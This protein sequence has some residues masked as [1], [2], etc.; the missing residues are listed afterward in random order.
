M[1]PPDGACLSEPER[2]HDSL[3]MDDFNKDDINTLQPP[4][5]KIQSV[6]GD[7]QNQ[8]QNDD[9]AGS[10]WEQAEERFLEL[11]FGKERGLGKGRF[12]YPQRSSK[13]SFDLTSN[14]HYGPPIHL[15]DE[16][17][18]LTS[19]C[20]ATPSSS[21][22]I[23]R[24]RTADLS[25]EQKTRLNA[26]R[27][28]DELVFLRPPSAATGRRL[29]SASA[30][31]VLHGDRGRR[32]ISARR[33]TMMG[34]EPLD[35]LF[36]PRK[37]R[38]L[39]RETKSLFF[40]VI[41]D[42]FRTAWTA[43]SV[44]PD[45]ATVQ[46]S[47]RHLAP[48]AD[49]AL[50]PIGTTG[51]TAGPK[52]YVR[53]PPQLGLHRIP[54]YYF[55]EE[56]GHVMVSHIAK[57]YP[58]PKLGRFSKRLT[59]SP[60]RI[61]ARMEG[62][63]GVSMPKMRGEER[64]EEHIN[65]GRPTPADVIQWLGDEVP[66][67]PSILLTEQ[68]DIDR[69]YTSLPDRPI[70]RPGRRLGHTFPIDFF[71]DHEDAQQQLVDPL[72]TQLDKAGVRTKGRAPGIQAPS[73]PDTPD[74]A[75]APAIAWH[76]CTV[77]SY[78]PTDNRYT[79]KWEEPLPERRNPPTQ[80]TR[81]DILLPHETPNAHHQK[82]L[83]AH[84]IRVEFEYRLALRQCVAIARP[85]LK[86]YIA[87][88]PVRASER[89]LAD[90]LRKR[91]KE[92]RQWTKFICGTTIGKGDHAGETE[93]EED[94]SLTFAPEVL[95]NLRAEIQNDYTRSQIEAALL[96]SGHLQRFLPQPLTIPTLSELHWQDERIRVTSSVKGQ[97]ARLAALLYPRIEFYRQKCTDAVFCL[98]NECQRLLKDGISDVLRRGEIP[99]DSEDLNTRC[100]FF[101]PKEFVEACA[102]I[103]G[104][105][106]Q[107][108]SEHIGNVL[109]A[110]VTTAF[111]A[112]QVEPRDSAET[113]LS[114]MEAQDAETARSL[115]KFFVA[116]IAK[117]TIM[118][119]F[120]TKITDIYKSFHQGAIRIRVDLI[121][122][123]NADYSITFS[124]DF[125]SWK[126]A[127]NKS[128]SC[129]LTPISCKFPTGPYIPTPEDHVFLKELCSEM[130]DEGIDSCRDFVNWLSA[131]ILPRVR[132]ASHVSVL[133]VDIA[134]PAEN[135]LNKCD[136]QLRDI[137]IV[138]KHCAGL[139][140]VT[141]RGMFAVFSENFQSEIKEWVSKTR[142][143]IFTNL[144]GLLDRK[145]QEIHDVYTTYTTHPPPGN[146]DQTKSAS[147]SLQ[148]L[149][150][151]LPLLQG[152][153]SFVKS[154]KSFLDERQWAVDDELVTRFYDAYTMYDR[155]TEF[156]A[157]RKQ[158]VSEA[159]ERLSAVV[160]KE[161]CM[162]VELWD[163][164][165]AAL[166]KVLTT[167]IGDATSSSG[168]DNEEQ[169][170]EEDR[171]EDDEHEDARAQNHPTTITL[172]SLTPISKHIVNAL[173]IAAV[174]IRKASCI[175]DTQRLSQLQNLHTSMHI[176]RVLVTCLLQYREDLDR[177]RY[178]PI[179][180]IHASEIR[181]RCAELL[182]VF[183]PTGIA[184]PPIAQHAAKEIAAFLET[185]YPI[186]E[187]LTYDSFRSWHWDSVRN[188][189]GLADFDITTTPLSLVTKTIGRRNLG[190]T[191]E[192]LLEI[193]QEA[194][195]EQSLS[196][197]LSEIQNRFAQLSIQI[198]RD[199]AT[200]LS[201]I[202]RFERLIGVIES[203]LLSVELLLEGSSEPGIEHYVDQFTALQNDLQR[204]L[205]SLTEWSKT[206][207]LLL[208]THSFF[209]ATEV[210]LA[211]PLETK[212]YR[213][214]ETTYRALLAKAEKNLGMKALVD[215]APD[216]AEGLTE[217]RGVLGSLVE[218][219]QGWLDG[220]RIGF[221]RLFF[222]A[223]EELL[224]L[225]KVK[226]EPKE[227]NGYLSKYFYFT[228]L[229]HQSS[230]SAA[231]DHKITGIRSTT[232]G[233]SEA[234][235]FRNFISTSHL[236]IEELLS[237]I[238]TQI[239][240]TLKEI[241]FTVLR[242]KNSDE[243][244]EDVPEQIRV[245]A[246]QV[247]RTLEVENSLGIKG[248]LD[249]LLSQT[250]DKI[251][252]LTTRSD[253]LAKILLTLTL[254]HRDWIQCLLNAQRTTENMKTSLEWLNALKY[255]YDEDEVTVTISQD[256]Y[257]ASYGFEYIPP[258]AR[259][260]LGISSRT[261]T[262]L[263]PGLI[264]NHGILSHG[265]PDTGKTTL[266]LEFTQILGRF[267]VVCCCSP[268]V[269]SAVMRR[270]L[271]GMVLTGCFL[272]FRQLDRLS[273][274]SLGVCLAG[275]EAVR[276]LTAASSR[277]ELSS[278]SFLG[279]VMKLPPV[280][281]VRCFA[282]SEKMDDD[283]FRGTVRNRMVPIALRLP[284]V[285][286]VTA[287]LLRNAGFKDAES[288]AAKVAAF[289]RGCEGL[290]V[291]MGSV[292]SVISVCRY[293]ERM[294]DNFAEL[295]VVAKCLWEWGLLKAVGEEVGI[296]RDVLGAVFGSTFEAISTGPP[297]NIRNDI[298]TPDCDPLH[299]HLKNAI[300]GLLTATSIPG[301]H[302]LVLGAPQTG[303]TTTIRAASR[304]N[305]MPLYTINPTALSSALLFG[306]PS[307]TGFTKGILEDLASSPNP[308]WIHLDGPY[309]SSWTEAVASL[310]HPSALCL[311]TGK[312]LMLSQNVTLIWE[313]EDIHNVSA[314]FISRF[315]LVHVKTKWT[316][317]V[318]VSE[319]IYQIPKDPK[320]SPLATALQCTLKAIFGI[321]MKELV[322]SLDEICRLR[323]MDLQSSV[324]S[325]LGILQCLLGEACLEKDC[326][327]VIEDAFWYAVVWSFGLAVD[328]EHRKGF[329][330]T[331]YR[332]LED[333]QSSSQL[334]AV[335]HSHH[336]GPSLFLLVFNTVTGSWTPS[337]T[338]SVISHIRNLAS[339]L[340]QHHKSVLFTG[341]PSA[342]K[343]FAAER[344]L[345]NLPEQKTIIH[346]HMLHPTSTPE[347][348]H[349][350]LHKTLVR[351]EATAAYVPPNN[352]TLTLF[353]DDLHI[354][355]AA[356]PSSPS[357]V[358]EFWR[359][360]PD[361]GGYWSNAT[362][363]RAVRRISIL[364][365]SD[366]E[367]PT[368][369]LA[370][371]FIV[372]RF[373]DADAY[374]EMRGSFLECMHHRG[375]K[376]DMVID[377]TLRCHHLIKMRIL[378]S[379]IRIFVPS[380]AA[381]VLRGLMKISEEEWMS[382]KSLMTAWCFEVDRVY[383]DRISP[384]DTSIY[385]DIVGR[386]CLQYFHQTAPSSSLS[387]LY[388]DMT[389]MAVRPNE[390]DTNRS[391]FTLGFSPSIRQSTVS[392]TQAAYMDRTAYRGVSEKLIKE[393]ISIFTT[394]GDAKG[395]VKRDIT[396]YPGAIDHFCR[397]DRVLGDDQ[398]PS[399]LLIG[400]CLHD[401]QK[402][403][404]KQASA[405]RGYRFREYNIIGPVDTPTWRL[406]IRK[407][408][409]DAAI[410]L[411]KIVVGIFLPAECALNPT[412]LGDLN[413]LLDRGRSVQLWTSGEYDDMLS[414][415]AHQAKQT[416]RDERGKISR[417]AVLGLVKGENRKA[418]S[419]LDV[420]RE[421][422][423]RTLTN[424]KIVVCVDMANLMVLDQL[425]EY[426]KIISSLTIDIY[427]DY[428]ETSLRTLA[429]NYFADS[430]LLE[431]VN[432]E[433]TSAESLS[434]CTAQMFL[435]VIH[436]IQCGSHP[437]LKSMPINGYEKFLEHVSEYYMNTKNE[438]IS[439]NQKF[440]RCLKK[441]G[442]ARE[443]VKTIV[444]NTRSQLQNLP[445]LL[446]ST[447]AQLN[448]VTKQ[449]KEKQMD[450]EKLRKELKSDEESI[451]RQ[452]RQKQQDAAD[453]CLAAARQNLEQSIRRLQALRKDA[454]EE[455]KAE[456][457]PP[458]P[459]QFLA[460]AICILFDKPQSW[461][462]ARKVI[463]SHSF[464]FRISSLT[465]DTLP[466]AVLD[467]LKKIME[468]PTF[469]PDRCAVVGIAARELCAWIQTLYSSS[470]EV[471]RIKEEQ[472]QSRLNTAKRVVGS[473]N[474]HIRLSKSRDKLIESTGECANLQRQYSILASTKR[475]LVGRIALLHEIFSPTSIFDA[476][477]PG[478]ADH[479]SESQWMQQA[480][481]CE[482]DTPVFENPK[483]AAAHSD[484]QA[485]LYELKT[486]RERL[487]SDVEEGQ[488]QLK[489]IRDLFESLKMEDIEE[490]LEPADNP[491]VLQAR[492]SLLDLL[493]LPAHSTP[494]VVYDKLRSCSIETLPVPMKQPTNAFGYHRPVLYDKN[495]AASTAI[496]PF[497]ASR[498]AITV[499]NI[500]P[501][502][503]SF[504]AK[505][506]RIMISLR[507]AEEVVK[508]KKA[509]F[510]EKWSAAYAG[511]AEF[512][513]FE[514]IVNTIK[515]I[516]RRLEIADLTLMKL[517]L[518]ASN[519]NP[520]LT[521]IIKVGCALVGWNADFSLLSKWVMRNPTL[522][523]RE[524]ANVKIGDLRVKDLIQSGLEG[525]N[526]ICLRAIAVRQVNRLYVDIVG[527]L[528]C[529]LG[530]KV[531]SFID[532]KTLAR[533]SSV[534][535]KW[536]D[537]LADEEFW[538]WMSYR[539]GWGVTF[540][541]PKD[542]DWKVFYFTLANQIEKR[543]NLIESSVKTN[544]GGLLGIKAY[545]KLTAFLKRLPEY[546][547]LSRNGR[548][549]A[550]QWDNVI[551]LEVTNDV[552]IAAE[553]AFSEYLAEYGTSGADVVLPV[554]QA[555]AKHSP[556]RHRKA[557]IALRAATGLVFPSKEVHELIMIR[558]RKA[559]LLHPTI[560]RFRKQP[561]QLRGVALITVDVNIPGTVREPLHL[562]DPPVTER[563]RASESIFTLLAEMFQATC[564][565]HDGKKTG[566]YLQFQDRFIKSLQ[567]LSKKIQSRIDALGSRKELLLANTLMRSGLLAYF[568]PLSDE[569]R[570]ELEDVWRHLIKRHINGHAANI[571]LT[572]D[573]RMPANSAL[574]KVKIVRQNLTLMH[575]TKRDKWLI[576]PNGLAKLILEQYGYLTSEGS[577]PD[578]LD[579]RRP[580]F[581]EQL[582]RLKGS[583]K[584]IWIEGLT[585]KELGR[586][587]LKFQQE[588]LKELR[589]S[590]TQR[591]PLVVFADAG[592]ANEPMLDK[593]QVVNF[594]HCGTTLQSLLFDFIMS[595][596]TPS[597]SQ[598]R[599]SM[600]AKL[601]SKKHTSESSFDACITMM[602]TC[603]ITDS[604]DLMHD[605]I[606][607]Q[608]EGYLVESMTEAYKA[609]KSDILPQYK[610]FMS[611]ATF[612][613]ELH[614]AFK[615]IKL[616]NSLYATDDQV[617]T[618]I[619]NDCL[620]NEVST[621]KVS[622]L[623]DSAVNKVANALTLQLMIKVNDMLREEDRIPVHFVLATVNARR[624]GLVSRNEVNLLEK[625]L[626]Y[627]NE[628]QSEEL[629]TTTIL[630]Q[631]DSWPDLH[632]FL[633][634]ATHNAECAA[635]DFFETTSST[636]VWS[637]RLSNMEKFVAT[638]INR[639]DMLK[640]VLVNMLTSYGL[641]VEDSSSDQFM[642]LQGNHSI[643][644]IVTDELADTHRL[645]VQGCEDYEGT[646]IQ[647]TIMTEEDK[648]GDKWKDKVSH[649][650]GNGDWLVIHADAY[651][652]GQLKAIIYMVQKSAASFRMW[653]LCPAF[654]QERLPADV[655][656]LVRVCFHEK[657]LSFRHLAKH[658][659]KH[660]IVRDNKQ[661]LPVDRLY[662]SVIYGHV[663]L[664]VTARRPETMFSKIVY[665]ND[666]DFDLSIT[667]IAEARNRGLPPA[668]SE[669]LLLE[670]VYLKE[671]APRY[672]KKRVESVRSS[673]LAILDEYV[674]P[675]ELD[676]VN[677]E[678][679]EKSFD[680]D[681]H[682]SAQESLDSKIGA[683]TINC[684]RLR[685]RVSEKLQL[686]LD[687]P[688]GPA[689]HASEASLSSLSMLDKDFLSKIG[690]FW[691]TLPRL[692]SVRHLYESASR[693]QN[694][695][696]LLLREAGRY[697]LV[698]RRVKQGLDA[699]LSGCDTYE[700]RHILK[701]LTARRIPHSWCLAPKH[702][703]YEISSYFQELGIAAQFLS[704]CTIS[705]PL[706][707]VSVKLP[708]S[709]TQV[710]HA[711]MMGY[712]NTHAV[713]L[714]RVKSCLE[715][716]VGSNEMNCLQAKDTL[717]ESSY[718]LTDLLLRNVRIQ[719]EAIEAIALGCSSI[720]PPLVL[721][722][723]VKN[724]GPLTTGAGEPPATN[725]MSE[726]EI[727]VP[728]QVISDSSAVHLDSPDNSLPDL[729]LRTRVSPSELYLHGVTALCSSEPFSIADLEHLSEL[730][731]GKSSFHASSAGSAPTFTR[732]VT[733]YL[734]S[735][736]DT[737]NERE[738]FYSNILP[739]LQHKM[740][741]KHI[742]LHVVD[743]RAG[744]PSAR[745]SESDYVQA[746]RWQ[747]RRADIF[748]SIIGSKLGDSSPDRSLEVQ[749]TMQAHSKLWEIEIDCALELPVQNSSFIF[750]FRDA[751][752]TRS[753]PKSFRSLYEPENS[754]AIERVE[755][756]KQQL[757]ESRCPV[758]IY[759]SYFSRIEDRRVK[760]GGLEVWG[761]QVAKDIAQC[762]DLRD[763]SS[764]PIAP[765]SNLTDFSG[766][767]EVLEHVRRA[768]LS[769]NNNP[770]AE[771]EVPMENT[772]LLHGESGMGKTTLLGK[773][774]S[775]FQANGFLVL[776]NFVR[777]WYGSFDI[778]QMLRRFQTQLSKHLE[779]ERIDIGT[780][781]S[782]QNILGFA[783][784]LKKV[785]KLGTNV[786]IIVDGVDRLSIL[787]S[788][789][790]H[791]FSWLPSIADVDNQTLL[792]VRW[793]FSAAD[794]KVLPALR[795][796][797][798][799]T[800]SWKLGG[801]TNQ[802]QKDILRMQCLRMNIDVEHRQ[803]QSILAKM[804]LSKP[805]Y[806]ALL[807]KKIKRT[808]FGRTFSNLDIPVDVA[809]MF[810][811]MLNEFEQI[812]GRDVI[813][814]TLTAI[815]SSRSGLREVEIIELL[816]LPFLDWNLIYES[817]KDL[818]A[819]TESGHLIPFHEE[820]TTA[821]K[822]RYIRSSADVT[823]QHRLLAMFYASTCITVSAGQQQWR[824]YDSH[825]AVDIVHH[826][827][828]A[829]F[830]PHETA[831]VLCNLGFIESAFVAGVGYEVVGF[832]AEVLK[833][834]QTESDNEL[835][836]RLGDY[837]LFV[838]TYG[839][840]L[841]Q[842][843]KMCFTLAYNLPKG[844]CPSVRQ[845]ARS[846]NNRAHGDSLLECITPSE[847]HAES[848]I[849]ATEATKLIAVTVQV[850]KAIGR[851]CL[852]VT[853][854]GTVKA[855]DIDSY[856]LTEVLLQSPFPAA[857]AV[858]CCFSLNGAER[859]AIALRNK[860]I[861]LYNLSNGKMI[862]FV[863]SS[864]RGGAIFFSESLESIWQSGEHTQL[865]CI[866][867][868]AEAPNK[869]A[870]RSDR[871]DDVLSVLDA[872][873]PPTQTKGTSDAV[874]AHSIDGHRI[875]TYSRRNKGIIVFNA[876]KMREI[877]RFNE[878][879]TSATSVG[880][881]S[882][883][884][885]LLAVTR[886]DGG[887]MIWRIDNHSRCALIH[888]PSDTP[889]QCLSFS[890]DETL[891]FCGTPLGV[892][893]VA[894]VETGRW[895][896]RVNTGAS[897]LTN[898]CTATSRGRERFLLSSENQL[899]VCNT[900]SWK[901]EGKI[902]PLMS[903]S[904][905]HH[906]KAVSH[907][908]FTRGN[909]ANSGL[910]LISSS[911]DKTYIIWSIDAN[912]TQV[913]PI[914][915]TTLPDQ[916]N[917]VH[918]SKME[919]YIASACGNLG[920][921]FDLHNHK[922]SLRI[923]HSSRLRRVT[924]S[925]LKTEHHGLC[926][927]T[928]GVHD[929]FT[930][931][932]LLRRADRS[933]TYHQTPLFQRH[934]TS[935]PSRLFSPDGTR[936][937]MANGNCVYM[938]DPHTG[939]DLQT[940]ETWEGER[941]QDLCWSASH[942]IIYCSASSVWVNGE[943]WSSGGS[944]GDNIQIQECRSHK[945]GKLFAYSAVEME[946]QGDIV[947]HTSSQDVGIIVVM[948][949]D[950][951]W[952]HCSLRHESGRIVLWSFMD[953]PRYIITIA[954]DHIMRVWD[955][956][957][958]SEVDSQPDHNGKNFVRQAR[959][960]GEVC[961]MVPL[962]S[963]PTSL[964]VGANQRSIVVGTVDGLVLVYL[965]R[966]PH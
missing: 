582:N 804:N 525:E 407:Q 798:P 609:F 765:V 105:F 389:T 388:S 897:C 442:D 597:F 933:L 431:A 770:A 740:L 524:I 855:W 257:H 769:I 919:N 802:E 354:P 220:K 710:V 266:L 645:V 895:I 604:E 852:T 861:C 395:L 448:V 362:T 756:L 471:R 556:L 340:L 293:M 392:L 68:K 785:A 938:V 929:T 161:M 664:V 901:N 614:T 763:F 96:C 943:I 336:E 32:I 42:I 109:S 464:I 916:P 613:C 3:P 834:A 352:K 641:L 716:H 706:Q 837:N 571:P 202:S 633:T 333:N 134:N 817:L 254:S 400:H 34:G 915:Q 190:L 171:T 783:T 227:L 430:G 941:V 81:A 557:F 409:I 465:A 72:S 493:Q 49:H 406:F 97:V 270:L 372:F 368:H 168:S 315:S 393:A 191:Y 205:K 550:N 414:K 369:R 129:M 907:L 790:Q 643:V 656:T 773:I 272:V 103:H 179:C 208:S 258:T 516:R 470:R 4:Y 472:S 529:Q 788:K 145:V 880:A 418:L 829:G 323:G 561:S 573:T 178:E 436:A 326:Q 639:P 937:A 560:E 922:E 148:S 53:L 832:I 717:S 914:T 252:K 848:I 475:E 466:E 426:P 906:T 947:N 289:W 176:R 335:L 300:S 45:P 245:L 948:R 55:D 540:V 869:S 244:G 647:I 602:E 786:L 450:V 130:I 478:H 674:K 23:I 679:F 216:L 162:I 636:N 940:F 494:T 1:Q 338:H 748:L 800:K 339:T 669:T 826:Q 691:R 833:R 330:A 99:Y 720:L 865:E 551:Q 110:A 316:W 207:P 730:N 483:V 167:P 822:K 909:S 365:C 22:R 74:P 271:T 37:S 283:L 519:P 951:P 794:E 18:D 539:R 172:K 881:F 189:L 599:K 660:Y 695:R 390:R 510:D 657:N 320:F 896:K 10:R 9:E 486:L 621:L 543:I 799:D 810:D 588:R 221:P 596:A 781:T 489:A 844:A 54:S 135:I 182:E 222:G 206:Q 688:C 872:D 438:L 200:G 581:V 675:S 904:D 307:Q 98:R 690:R 246:H 935:L 443:V 8:T 321:Y 141:P 541:Y 421:L 481:H 260:A 721:R 509:V 351:D 759:Q 831:R 261:F 363:F 732:Y 468:E 31:S 814:G 517:H 503:R 864:Y 631:L 694:G 751:A 142:R 371:H 262:N 381:K 302:V 736:P 230:A 784:K 309:S 538:K 893:T 729:S 564:A 451:D 754:R 224:E 549:S 570:V 459:V 545:A 80:L 887:I 816:K 583:W 742:L 875:A 676:V 284:G 325:F 65:D 767:S 347:E 608:R 361:M 379:G 328:V 52:V 924:L 779:A 655:P 686:L 416:E 508:Q 229:I 453:A 565:F 544:M 350:Q 411:Q 805:L 405:M 434:T 589:T 15:I 279:R 956:G 847:S 441:V 945:L 239:Q 449:L 566:K 304:F 630:S 337:P 150:A 60:S 744:H 592:V 952:R 364:G 424:L 100:I 678:N 376:V 118:P 753:V 240:S 775:E 665:F 291:R 349:A 921:V 755:K 687:C 210:Q 58:L 534:N 877:C 811:Q 610:P 158:A 801:L 651:W 619:F 772:L 522:F 838:E 959:A 714:E 473:A 930:A 741:R 682:L 56:D 492:A 461:T 913:R 108:V 857:S 370:R 115:L 598:Q 479:I 559:G 698:F 334:W 839:H 944:E 677:Y 499:S 653:F 552:F 495:V 808:E 824:K 303:K 709:V 878:E 184:H 90:E 923:L 278:V 292:R 82:L 106:V 256:L 504:K 394:Q 514:V 85:F 452:W 387:Y 397:L 410:S 854:E 201:V 851:C 910:S 873:M 950:K 83:H 795:K 378:R 777:T 286:I 263:W 752:F 146:F 942:Q 738:Y 871:G 505:H 460:S 925:R 591:S 568:G 40:K 238:E 728:A 953:N 35:D 931:W 791:D 112:H 319:W 439:Q 428:N 815:A 223:D 70:S 273:Q 50:V 228:S 712:C 163:E 165:E 506:Q 59:P 892:I 124:T 64:E 402:D 46:H 2:K 961:A 280:V 26:F 507:E 601:S 882:L 353:V 807:L 575:A 73:G 305:S 670:S 644:L 658:F 671:A 88:A 512:W 116:V 606:L 600:Q 104:E 521:K 891:L 638:L 38:P 594:T 474:A 625:V 285:E 885:D 44:V 761:L 782:E 900:H 771:G 776:T 344:T 862:A 186:V 537:L 231:Q 830:S 417:G 692:P 375:N 725:M 812:H 119:I 637:R 911:N 713:P 624:R 143:R 457:D 617:F 287:V 966:T 615:R 747:I 151:A 859:V 823:H 147:V 327:A 93:E 313:A 842:Y 760:M 536:A 965:I 727:S 572:K 462:E 806:L 218:D 634:T 346:T 299:M 199:E 166:D 155:L 396:L 412:F 329:E 576:D 699:I 422:N 399:A 404:A 659:C 117:S 515:D 435:A 490:L 175:D 264:S 757:S 889:I 533:G 61:E 425:A 144:E 13:V 623:S 136:A 139:A 685:K 697:N 36:L 154:L 226:R 707:F 28:L 632:E 253:K 213:A 355:M 818:L 243:D 673:V 908:D 164:V 295:E 247:R 846:R 723:Y 500:L 758:H 542:M 955:I 587:I 704:G 958:A 455:L 21:N 796:R 312:R 920:I 840:Y 530:L 554:K 960:N 359:S 75:L 348:F 137:S 535:R 242:N 276:E 192:D 793:L 497:V 215:A 558:A 157:L 159:I 5:T 212:R 463:A 705:N 24:P 297:C 849:V 149:D 902:V 30:E 646:Q 456:T 860:D 928:W 467:K 301:T 277:K 809:S 296:L 71:M 384:S 29:G 16:S 726:Y 432:D 701:I 496:T 183:T 628:N 41:A 314:G 590:I 101:T 185:E 703:E 275:L 569:K 722:L 51:G 76:P 917:S 672:Q 89:L 341:G 357:P 107:T 595:N 250:L 219:V 680:N 477:E 482:D 555:G 580:D 282:T 131:A 209:N 17:D 684:Q 423:E 440:R 132:S 385:H 447:M 92:R 648:R 797:H 577:E 886:I 317:E 737:Y 766:R 177:W 234:L 211:L 635:Y 91:R 308:A 836:T 62:Y 578:R 787:G 708:I 87:N 366:L 235:I 79:I 331:I 803:V 668:I 265:P 445:A 652:I 867:F 408:I 488:K 251:R 888:T 84:A 835:I 48:A 774:C 318:C 324:S 593:F 819:E 884:R 95:I 603:S 501:A 918:V 768:F 502:I 532:C 187:V 813:A 77:L 14:V 391:I 894:E 169:E 820:F 306:S 663:G 964:A 19:D 120:R 427:Y 828:T 863:E 140:K 649:A 876:V 662:Y 629:N 734:C 932:Q 236:S 249:T 152:Q 912:F 419:A 67:I 415:I 683:G 523:L 181:K 718:I 174:I 700:S 739:Q 214:V 255:H 383:L 113:M 520:L 586:E 196:S 693:V 269:S 114:T 642:R 666:V 401:V 825:R 518:T 949:L 792:R 433:S 237:K 454:F 719:N 204:A 197:T 444:D 39:S 640:P 122:D 33:A 562:W 94:E 274:D 650:A 126:S 743:F 232:S 616:L 553:R 498:A 731:W 386:V 899:L 780:G 268:A 890:A 827:L 259:V 322:S 843:P 195:Q 735:T 579:A 528:P 373:H 374:C 446:E 78:D 526:L 12:D 248:G 574:F 125:E 620:R 241:I 43:P 627:L 469:R 667:I 225:V 160:E 778:S 957:L 153:T 711:A 102:H 133:D 203:D 584:P 548:Q 762:I 382:S 358:A 764:L 180:N 927:Y 343:T 547:Q 702:L 903:V 585:S 198:M 622:A 356:R 66:H 485:A 745:V 491:Y 57:Q 123:W 484:Y 377:A 398:Y 63:R 858:A 870:P 527:E 138:E 170:E 936:I 127:L 749:G 173:D 437:F 332:L 866:D 874:I 868:D 487:A 121:F 233:T 626:V 156:A 458:P 311:S 563:S 194:E 47:D 342:G 612:G 345:A 696:T 6:S 513:S 480:F 954:A 926:L 298:V 879:L 789:K 25:Q 567:Q 69:H 963:Q 128:L 733:V 7:E 746:S 934:C 217:M 821:I 429:Q 27:E 883:G 380:D 689:L 853:D 898:M 367:A 856:V 724:E 281:H 267:A 193:L 618:Q 845:D 413:A 841:R 750:Y 290:G 939:H 905:P 294:R 946:E 850:Q 420:E 476:H 607:F 661:P 611:L 681:Q 962:A 288:C 511:R 188:A 111:R 546:V 654:V 403:L 20:F 86:D 360:F 531:L 11:F 310:M 605:I 715:F